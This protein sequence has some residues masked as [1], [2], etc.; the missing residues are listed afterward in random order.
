M[1]SVEAHAKGKLRG[2]ILQIHETERAEAE[3][4]GEAA[5]AV[6]WSNEACPAGTMSVDMDKAAGPDVEFQ[7]FVGKRSGVWA[8][9]H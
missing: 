9:T 1:S 4:R 5:R 2:D 6:H 3:A 7:A 8:T